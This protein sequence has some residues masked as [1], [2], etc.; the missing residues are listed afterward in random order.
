MQADVA[1]IPAP[2]LAAWGLDGAAAVPL[3]N[4][5][6]NQT[7][8]ADDG[9]RRLVLQQLN[10]L[11]PPAINLDIE[12]LTAHL[13]AQG[14][15]T[16]RLAR[17]SAGAAWYE[18]DGHCWRALS[19]VDGLAVD[20]VRDVAMA[21][22]AGALLG[23]FHR[24]VA[25][26]D[27]PLHGTR[28]G[29]H[30]TP[31]HLA[32]L[33]AALA[34]HRRHPAWHQVA[35]LGEAILAAA[36]GLAPLPPGLPARLVHGDPKLNNLLFDRVTGAGLCLVDLD[37]LGR[38]PVVL[39]LGDALRSWCNPAGEDGERAAFSL[40]FFAAALAGYAAA[41]GDWLQPAERDAVLA[42]TETIILELAARFCADA[43]EERYFGWDP[44]RYTS[45]GE[46]NR[47]RAQR[48]LALFHSLQ[49]QREAAAAAAA[50]AFHKPA[51]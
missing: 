48:Q 14:L 19:W 28:S 17:T 2:V 22:E 6:I 32:A 45:R 4:G 21:R 5:L 39:E 38:M 29:I 25:D 44:V 51:H 47:Q 50:D 12:A 18:L 7:W 49:C 46:H 35:P 41:T 43:L 3:G 13:A 15:T 34:A 40:P 16:P 26:F 36:A 37:T 24:A 9:R 8:L 11:F 33:R 30:D 31:R 20:C 23:R 1:E 42:G 27:R 10:P